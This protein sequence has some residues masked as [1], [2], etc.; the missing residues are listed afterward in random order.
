MFTYGIN[1][2]IRDTML[3]YPKHLFDVK[4]DLKLGVNENLVE[5]K[6]RSLDLNFDG[7]YE[8][9]IEEMGRRLKKEINE[10]Y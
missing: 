10:Y 5:L 1:F 7:S 3:L 2:N 9:F 6:M 4:E 8:K